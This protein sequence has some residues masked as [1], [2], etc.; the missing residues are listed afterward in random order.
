MSKHTGLM[1]GLRGR[2]ARRGESMARDK[3]ALRYRSVPPAALAMDIDAYGLASLRA[4]ESICA[5]VTR[6]ANTMGCMPIHLYKD[7]Q[8]QK[9]H[10]LEKLIAFAPNANM[11]PF[12]M[13]Y[14][15]QACLGIYGRAYGLIVPDG[16]GGVDSIDVLDPTRVQICR[17]RETREIWYLVALDEGRQVYVHTSAMLALRWGSTD[18]IHS[19]SPIEVLGATLKYDKAIK[20]IS[21]RQ[22]EG[23]NGAVT[24]TYPTALSEPRKRD[25][26][27]QFLNVYRK[28]LGQVIVLEGGVTADR[29]SG[30][31]IDPNVL[32][33]DSI[34]KSK[35]AAVYNMPLRMV[36]A[37]V[38]SDYSTSEQVTQELI[39]LTMLPYV[40]AWEEELN[41]KL[42]M[43][44]MWSEGYRF[45]ASMDAMLRGDVAATA[46]KHS[47]GI[48]SGKYTPNEA[49]A[50]DNL[51]PLPDGDE[52]MVARDLIPLRVS[53]QNPELLL[54]GK[55]D[56]PILEPGN[57][58]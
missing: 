33:S 9:D 48:R 58:R 50:E 30:S 11:T 21:L 3:P 44:G 4:S 28:S 43:Y 49:R 2:L 24:L 27:E 40:E 47:K 35:I 8:I 6:L 32:S 34:T 45:R 14:A 10:P 25:I 54:G 53:V 37:N 55:S 19:L 51:P 1:A 12:G 7:Y 17:N 41:R 36:G 5:A 56:E 26:E 18:G 46:E 29:I 22:L 38:N 52:L 15:M 31:V 20:E 39:T 13:R 42:L 57:R 23:V 16:R